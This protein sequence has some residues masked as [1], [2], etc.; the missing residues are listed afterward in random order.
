MKELI[1]TIRVWCEPPHEVQGQG[2][3][4]VMIPFTGEATGE[5]FT[6]KTVGTGVDTQRFW[7]GGKMQLSARYMLAGQDSSGAKCKVFI[8]N[9]L[10]GPEGWVPTIVTDS[11]VLS[12]WENVPLA[13]TVE[14]AEG[15][16]I[17][18]IYEKN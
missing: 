5:H 17:V 11:K 2:C 14:G 10:R 13:A 1:M 12:K 7:E 4:V 6:G 15:G 16:V 9:S 8:E 3:K 18:K